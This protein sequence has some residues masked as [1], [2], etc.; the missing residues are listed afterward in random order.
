M[1]QRNNTMLTEHQNTFPLKQKQKKTKTFRAGVW[2]LN[3]E[4]QRGEAF[5]FAFFYFV[6]SW[7]MLSMFKNS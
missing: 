6:T 3:D 5:E 4:D 1:S 2:N 7:L